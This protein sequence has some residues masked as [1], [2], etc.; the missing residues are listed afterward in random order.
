[1]TYG[2][3]PKPRGT[4]ALDDTAPWDCMR[5]ERR[6]PVSSYYAHSGASYGFSKK[7]RD[8]TKTAMRAYREERG[9]DHWR[10]RKM[11]TNFGLTRAAFDEIMRRQAHGCAICKSPDP[12]PRGWHIDH[13]HACCPQSARSCGACV[14]GAL[15]HNCNLMLGHAKD[16]IETLTRAIQ[17]LEER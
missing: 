16:R 6:L 7:C 4:L 15:C 10:Y 3:T 12:G 14:R 11:L 5:C 9:A 2:P 1:M 13:D 17:Y 8:C